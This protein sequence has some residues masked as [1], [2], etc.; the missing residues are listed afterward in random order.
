MVVITKLEAAARQL[1]TAIHLFFCN[2]DAV[3]V[4]S[5]AASAFNVFADLAERKGSRNSWRVRMRDSSDLS[6]RDLNRLLRE[7]WNFFKHAEHDPDGILHFDEQETE[8]FLFMA[9]LESGN[10]FK[11]TCC[12]QAY[13]L[14]YIATHPQS[15]SPDEPVFSRTSELFPN[16]SVLSRSRQIEAGRNFLT[17]HCANEF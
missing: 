14:W 11:T 12:M 15:C 9:V 8:D 7:G 6:M 2:G 16:I 1:D 13:Q 17:A 5:L 3:S 10:L 4:H